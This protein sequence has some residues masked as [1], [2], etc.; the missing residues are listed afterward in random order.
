LLILR[1]E[2]HFNIIIIRHTN[3]RVYFTALQLT[4]ALWLVAD[5]EVLPYQDTLNFDKSENLEI[6]TETAINYSAC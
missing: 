3:Q 2:N 6:R 5:F 1:L 4:L